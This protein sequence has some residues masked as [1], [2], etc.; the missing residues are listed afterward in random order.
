MK[1]TMAVLDL[2]SNSF[3]MLVAE[4]DDFQN[5]RVIDKLKDKVRLA[6]GLDE[7]KF[8]D[9]QTQKKALHH[10]AQYSERL[11]GIPESYIRVVATDT[12]RRAKNGVEFLSA[13]QTALDP[14]DIDSCRWR[15]S[16]VGWT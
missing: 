15:W 7:R 9:D 10:F 12:F 1:Q 3:H 8:L 2:G 11:R 16:G 13:A 4:V 5:I 6:G 14:E